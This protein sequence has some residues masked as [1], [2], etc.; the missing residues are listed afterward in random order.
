M[1]IQALLRFL[2]YNSF[3]LMICQGVFGSIP[4]GVIGNVNLY[5]RLCGFSQSDLAWLGIPGLFGLVG[6]F[7][8]GVVSDA[9]NKQIGPRSRGLTAVITVA[10]GIPLQYML[11]YGIAP[12][13]AWN[14]VY[15]F[16]TILILFNLLAAWAQPG[17]NFPILGQIVTGKDRNK[18][19]CWE[20]CFENSMAMI[21]GSR[22]VPQVI[23]WLGSE[24]IKYEGTDLEQA[25]I[26]GIAQT[27][28]ICVPNLICIVVYALLMWSFPIDVKRVQAEKE[29][30][31][32]GAELVAG[33]VAS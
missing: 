19:M 25:R 12:G 23:A 26:L 14:N 3:V 29:S 21:I 13:S 6:G 16:V 28:V 17:C 31:T 9:L 10:M 2:K 8:G 18:V 27:V 11:W 4:W 22:A 1:G 15:A 7:L 33:E 32:I 5:A 24:D 30:E 20:L